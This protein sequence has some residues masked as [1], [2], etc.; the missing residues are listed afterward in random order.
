MD[1]ETEQGVLEF[2]EEK[3]RLMERTFEVLGRFEMNGYSF[4]AYVLATHEVL[5]PERNEAP[6]PRTIEDVLTGWK[7]GEPFPLVRAELCRLP[8]FVRLVIP[9]DQ[10]TAFFGRAIRALSEKSRA[11]GTVV[12][13]EMWMAR[14]DHVPGETAEEARSKLPASLEDYEGRTEGLFLR[15]EHKLAGSRM[16][17]KTIHRNPDRLDA[18]WVLFDE[19]MGKSEGRLVNLVP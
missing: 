2:C 3:R 13:G 7:T 1:L 14:P 5:P 11:I 8:V 12:M 4:G 15:L 19:T 18:D 16:W 9:E 10:H 17:T 6:P